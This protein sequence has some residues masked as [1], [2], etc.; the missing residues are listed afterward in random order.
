MGDDVEVMSE[1]MLVVPS[2]RNCTPTTPTS[3]VDVAA[4]E[5]DEPFTVE[6]DVGKVIETFGGLVSVVLNDLIE[7]V[8]VPAEFTA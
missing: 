3:S 8:E 6:P 5:T 4:S 2:R 1:P 7:P